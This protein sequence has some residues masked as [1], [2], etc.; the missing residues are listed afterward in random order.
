MGE[1]EPDIDVDEKQAGFKLDKACFHLDYDVIRMTHFLCVLY[2]VS[3]SIVLFLFVQM[4]KKELKAK[5]RQLTEAVEIM[6]DQ[7][8]DF[9]ALERRM[10][11]KDKI[12][13]TLT[14]MVPAFKPHGRDLIFNDLSLVFNDCM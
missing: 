5:D 8:A 7:R 9:D 13:Q 3:N 6:R 12:I 10:Q 2:T 1:F 14:S 4:L 11:D